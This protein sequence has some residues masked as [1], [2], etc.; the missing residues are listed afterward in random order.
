[1][2]EHKEC[3]KVLI[4]GGAGGVGRFLAKILKNDFYVSI[5]DI[6]PDSEKIAASLGINFSNFDEIKDFDIV[7][8][9][10]P[11]KVA[12]NII[13]EVSQ[14]MK[15]G[16]LL[17]DTSSVKTDVVSSVKNDKIY[18]I[19]VHP[20]FAPTMQGFKGQVVTLTPVKVKDNGWLER[21]RAF[22]ERQGAHVEI[23]SSEEHDYIMSVVQ[24]LI[25]WV[26]ISFGVT[27]K[28]IG[29]DINKSRRFATPIYEVMLD[30]TARIL[31]QD[32]NLY[33]YIQ[34]NPFAADVREKFLNVSQRLNDAILSGDLD[35]FISMMK[36]AS[37]KFGDAEKS[38]QKSEKVL[39]SRIIEIDNINIGDEVALEHIYSKK[40]HYGIVEKVS[41]ID[42]VIKD[43]N[44]SKK[45][46]LKVE[47]I[48]MLSGQEL[49]DWKSKNLKMVKRDISVQFENIDNISLDTLCEVI[50]MY[51]A[52]K[53]E[54]IDIF[55]EKKSLTFRISVYEDEDISEI[56]RKVKTFL[57]GIGGKIR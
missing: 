23:I 30:I 13:A 5:Y 12:P 20:L 35:Y 2:C 53:V 39:K 11:L 6:N 8:V 29:F 42:L 25:H 52:D 16:A 48:R 28:E 34:K 36:S 40:I 9:S 49:N 18:F 55:K 19:A 46:R 27:L 43:K 4:V 21:I 51:G 56:E 47:N 1:M 44:S 57:S 33:A 14:E 41:P 3:I 15:D 37:T 45:T 26:I 24:S 38:I 31:A 50:K 10:V 7:I 54:V 22:L 32:P 17:L